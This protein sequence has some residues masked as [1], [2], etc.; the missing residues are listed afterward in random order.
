MLRDILLSAFVSVGSALEKQRE[1][2]LRDRSGHGVF[3]EVVGRELERRSE[4]Q[5][6]VFRLGVGHEWPVIDVYESYDTYSHVYE[7]YYTYIRVRL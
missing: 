5:E 2:G 7:S 4:L 6:L 1:S 3:G